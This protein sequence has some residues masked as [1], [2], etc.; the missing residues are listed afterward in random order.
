MISRFIFEVKIVAE[1][2]QAQLVSLHCHQLSA[3]VPGSQEAD[4]DP[5]ALCA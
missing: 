2:K 4:E 1:Q 5:G 3:A